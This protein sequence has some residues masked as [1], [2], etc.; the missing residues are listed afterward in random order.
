[1]AEV[2]GSG[3]DALRLRRLDQKG[4]AQGSHYVHTR[5]PTFVS[6]TRSLLHPSALSVS[7]GGPLRPDYSS[8]GTHHKSTTQQ[9]SLPASQRLGE[10]SRAQ[11][12]SNRRDA[13][14]TARIR[15]FMTHQNLACTAAAYP[16]WSGKSRCSYLPR[17]GSC[18]PRPPAKSRYRSITRQSKPA[19]WLPVTCASLCVCCSRHL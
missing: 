4:L 14:A 7:R 15:G 6:Q 8:F 12:H 19:R 17:L 13:C 5:A 10:P 11:P 2:E 9:P 18:I 3:S 1:M 16:G